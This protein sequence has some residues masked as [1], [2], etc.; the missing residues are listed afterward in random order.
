MKR[1][2]L[3]T[4][5]IAIALGLVAA[6]F[7]TWIQLDGAVIYSLPL[8]LVGA[9]RSRAALWILAGSLIAATFL[10][11]ALQIPAGS[12]ALNETFFVNRVLDAL[13]LLLVAGVLHLWMRSTTT[14]EAQSR[15]I[16]EQN[17]K[18]H[19]ARATRRM[20][21]VQEAERRAISS[22][23]HDLVGQK[24]TALSINLNIA[25]S[26]LPPDRTADV[27]VRLDDSLKMIEETTESIRDVMAELRPPVL[28]DFGLAPALRW[29]ADEFTQRTGVDTSV[30]EEGQARRL[31]PATEHSLFRMAQNA[32][33]NVVKHAR[34]DKAVMT[35][36]TTPDSICLTVADNGDGFVPAA[37][38]APTQDR[39]WGLMIMRERAAAIGARLN[40]DSAPGH[41]TRVV[42][43][44]NEYPDD[45][46]SSGR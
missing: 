36:R 33:A 26:H 17:E 37:V 44:L 30:V 19:A 8:V 1:T 45:Q 25:R 2:A 11:Y 32:L 10:V 5:V 14:R 34:A 20:V 22:R 35:L 9:L 38:P 18:L 39:G 42:V 41:G 24:L 15:L 46:S 27:R 12:F 40:I 21:E 6:D 3:L 31:A 7:A 23:L 13:S 28:D 16:E 4:V 43:T 29:Y